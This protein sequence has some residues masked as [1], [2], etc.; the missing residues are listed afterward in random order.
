MFGLGLPFI[1][2]WRGVALPL[3]SIQKIS[4]FILKKLMMRPIHNPELRLASDLV[5]YTNRNVFLTGKAGTGKTTFL[6]NLK[7]LS[8]KRMVVVAPTGVAAINAGGVTIHSFFQLP[9]GPLV[10]GTL[11]S[12]RGSGEGA[13]SRVRKFSREKINIIRSIDLLVI[14][15]ISMVR[16]DLLDGMDEVLRQYRN[17]GKPFGGVQLLMIG[18]LHQLAPV[19]KDDEWLMLKDHYDSYFFFGSQALQKAGY[20]SLELK[21]IYRQSDRE[22]IDLLNRVRLNQMDAETLGALNKRYQPNIL[23]GNQEGYII[24]TTHNHQSKSIN[25]A[26]LGQLPGSTSRF[27]ARVTG[28]FPEYSY[29]T[30]Y[31]LELKVG[32]QV[33]FIKN[34]NSPGKLFYNGKIGTIVDIGD[35]EIS[36]SCEGDNESI[37]VKQMEW[38]N[39][40]YSID[41]ETKGI[42]ESIVGSFVQYP[43][44]LAWAITIHKSQG[45]TFERAIVDAQA[46]FAFGQVYVALSRCR[47]LQGLVLSSQ[48]RLT[49]VKTNSTIDSVSQSIERNQPSPSDLSHWR[50]QYQHELLLELF[51]FSAPYK[52]LETLRKGLRENLTSIDT[53][54]IDAVNA[55]I[56]DFQSGVMEVSAKFHKELQQ[57]VRNGADAENH[58]PLTERVV[59]ACGY[60]TQTLGFGT[61]NSLA[62]LSIDSDSKAVRKL[63]SDAL[64]K[65]NDELEVKLSCLKSCSKGFSTALYLDARG[66]GA[67]EATK[68]KG[69]RADAS[70]IPLTSAEHPDLFAIIRSWRN[71]KAEAMGVPAYMILSQKLL[72]AIA[73]LLPTTHGALAAIKG[74]GD[75]RVKL[76]ADELTG[77]VKGYCKDKGVA[78][79]A[80]KPYPDEGGEETALKPR[81]G[82]TK[83]LS[84]KLLREGK[85]IPEIARERCLAQSTIE[86]HLSH[87]IGTGELD[88]LML[89]NPERVTLISNL[90]KNNQS[91][92]L[93]QVKDMLD[94]QAT[95]GELKF[96]MKHLMASGEIGKV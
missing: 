44:K 30:D 14:D 26:K 19:V 8:P 38:N 64:G 85:T 58:A 75:K 18:D 5:Q 83:L 66:K 11:Y 29:P 92:G 89:M 27:S 7:A 72:I 16:A 41:E 81:K 32:A 84:L 54:L 10:P 35:D 90:I 73:S 71:R 1:C 61:L 33:M 74:F 39:V 24:L 50:L 91:L 13:E 37:S 28:N 20:V 69:K 34:D 63:L 95:Y 47:T 51:D 57:Y 52:R 43:L 15:E 45:L 46:A 80:Q 17:R 94:E 53:K 55:I 31:E 96:V 12:G 40:M 49:S 59:K 78:P 42:S 82:E 65:A 76:Y 36:V 77:I 62:K 48:L 2:T 22:F 21:H 3:G 70:P 60:F 56:S 67:V 9:F 87:F 88:I 93:S 68:S 25:G 86:T 23:D 79:P 6:H 4:T